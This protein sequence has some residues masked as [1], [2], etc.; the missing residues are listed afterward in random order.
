M[1]K[2]VNRKYYLCMEEKFIASAI[3]IWI[4]Y[5]KEA[6]INIRNA[7]KGIERSVVL[8]IKDVDGK[9][10]QLIEKIA[11]VTYAKIYVK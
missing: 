11:K 4:D 9:F 1:E 8:C 5:G 2:L 6:E 10:L 7:K 3:M